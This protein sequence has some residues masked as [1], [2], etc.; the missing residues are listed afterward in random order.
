RPAGLAVSRGSHRP[1]V[2]GGVPFPRRRN[3]ARAHLATAARVATI[4]IDAP[5]ARDGV[6]TGKTALAPAC[7]FVGGAGRYEENVG[8]AG[9]TGGCRVERY[10]RRPRSHGARN[11]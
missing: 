2:A 1:P 5:S 8:G 10:R 3:P 6:T 9:R 11:P 7:S 4:A